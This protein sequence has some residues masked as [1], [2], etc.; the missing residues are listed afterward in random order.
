MHEQSS[1]Y[2]DQFREHY[3]SCAAMEYGNLY[4]LEDHRE[5]GL[6]AEMIDRISYQTQH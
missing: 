5:I 3:R 2:P 1:L 4:A 6:A